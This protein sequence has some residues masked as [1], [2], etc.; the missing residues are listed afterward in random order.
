MSAL[1]LM[2]KDRKPA[3]GNNRNVFV[4]SSAAGRGL[5]GPG[6]WPQGPGLG[7]GPGDRAVLHNHQ[8]RGP[9]VSLGPGAWGAGL[10]AVVSA[11]AQ[12]GGSVVWLLGLRA[13]EAYGQLEEQETPN[14]TRFTWRLES[15]PWL[16]GGGRLG[17]GTFRGGDR[18][19]EGLV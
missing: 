1:R 18:K 3:A 12:G 10:S 9:E 16:E 4:C 11:L 6:E 15:A 7:C 8:A 19:E 13:W 17:W 2:T 14:P 5:A